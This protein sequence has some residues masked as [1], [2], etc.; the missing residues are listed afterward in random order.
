MSPERNPLDLNNLPEDFCRDGKQVIEGSSS[1]NAGYRKKK[2]GAKEGK[3]ECGKVYE[4]R[5]CSL[6]FCKSQ[7][8]GG[9]MN[10]HRQERETETLNRARQL[11]FNNDNLIAPPHLGCQ[12][13]PHV[14]GGYHHQA[15]NIGDPTLSYR[16]QPPPVYPT[17]LFSGNS[18][19]L[20]PPGQPPQPP[21]QP[22]YMYPSPP[23]LLSFSSQYPT[24]H[25][26]DY[27]VGHVLSGNSHSSTPNNFM[28]SSTLPDGSNNYTC[29]GA[30]IG[31]GLGLGNGSNRGTE[32]LN[33]NGF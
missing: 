11:V 24:G 14:A 21:H 20:L 19:T 31:H 2:N 12:P 1:F 30:P 6:K 9:H 25:S 23:R 4:C 26:N 5:F 27:F 17:R 18:T 22:P 3:E 16:P 28:G 33:N 15:G 8:L 13:I 10:R 29:I 32:G 7:A